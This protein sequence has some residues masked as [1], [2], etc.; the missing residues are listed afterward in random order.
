MKA[1]KNYN[2]VLEQYIETN[3]ASACGKL[4]MKLLQR[5]LAVQQNVYQEM[6]ER[7]SKAERTVRNYDNDLQPLKAEAKRMLEEALVMTNGLGPDDKKGFEKLNKQFSKLPATIE[8]INDEL[9]T[10]QAKVFCMGNAPD[11]DNVSVI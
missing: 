6:M 10:A 9:K 5:E 1:F 2:V 4:E 7:R 11:G 8:E 3:H